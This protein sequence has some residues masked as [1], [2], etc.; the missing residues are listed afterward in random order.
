MVKVVK[1]VNGDKYTEGVLWYMLLNTIFSVCWTIL[2]LALV[3]LPQKFWHLFG[4][5]FTIG[6]QYITTLHLCEMITH[7]VFFANSPKCCPRSWWKS[8]RI[9]YRML[10][11]SLPFVVFF[12]CLWETSF[13]YPLVDRFWWVALYFIILFIQT[14]RRITVFHT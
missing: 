10:L 4:K 7:Y 6:Y 5:R 1:K 3:I 12:I 11:A 8:S 14:R 13:R 9:Y 2:I